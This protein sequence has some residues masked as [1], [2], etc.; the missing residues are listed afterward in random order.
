M[1][2][3]ER[4]ELQIETLRKSIEVNENRVQELV[5]KNAISEQNREELIRIFQEHDLTRLAMAKP[6]LIETRINE[7]TREAFSRL[8]S[9]TDPDS[10]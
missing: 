2:D 6:G 7:G 9:I 5:A 1:Q 4:K 8:E 3:S 10:L